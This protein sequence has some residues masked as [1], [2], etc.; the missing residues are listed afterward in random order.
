MALRRQMAGG[1]EGRGLVRRAG[2]GGSALRVE[3]SRPLRRRLRPPGPADSTRPVRPE[4]LAPAVCGGREKATGVGSA[5]PKARR[6]PEGLQKEVGFAAGCQSPV[7]RP[8]AGRLGRG[9]VTESPEPEWGAAA[10][11]WLCFRGAASGARRAPF[12]ECALGQSALAAGLPGR[13]PTLPP[14]PVLPA[15]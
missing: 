12:R 10:R 9:S 7:C 3:G 13:C 4:P 14:L 15:P 5:G 8:G 1:E 2:G 6:N 11:P